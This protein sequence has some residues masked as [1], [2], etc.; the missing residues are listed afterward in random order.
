M[1]VRAR[2]ARAGFP[3]PVVPGNI[4][5]NNR[6][7]VRNRDGT[8]STVRSISIGTDQGEVLIPTVTDD[9]RAVSDEE[10]VEIY[11]RTGRHLGIFRTPEE[12]TG[13][14]ERLHRQ[15]ERQYARPRRGS[16]S[17]LDAV[18]ARGESG[19]RDFAE[20]RPVRSS[21]GALY[22]MQVMPDTARDPGFGI[23]PVRDNSPAEF[24][25]VGREYRSVMQRRYGGDLVKMWAA[26]NWGP[27][28]LDNALR[29][30]GSDWYRHAPA[31]TRRYIQRNLRDLERQ[32]GP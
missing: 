31:E 1:E 4:D 6:P 17:A 19:N 2:V 10:A 20:G 13:Y 12:A 7:V 22:A 25:R 16:S 5:L 21:A 9:G 28:N 8:I 24:N 18:T 27:G 23:A 30:H 29:R 11:R 32:R 26:Y 3:R 15:Q 14:A